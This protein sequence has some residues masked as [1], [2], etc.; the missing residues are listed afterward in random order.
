MLPGV[1]AGAWGVPR[2]GIT[3]GGYLCS[4]F[5]GCWLGGGETADPKVVITKQ[6]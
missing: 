1:P 3:Y 4:F 6:G 2:K 5:R